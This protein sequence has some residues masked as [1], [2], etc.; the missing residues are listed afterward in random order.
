MQRMLIL[1]AALLGAGWEDVVLAQKA[2][3]EK[4]I[5]ESQPAIQDQIHRIYDVFRRAVRD[6]LK[7]NCEAFD[8]IQRLKNMTKDKGE[9]VKQLAIFT[10]TTES[11]EDTHVMLAGSILE[12]LNLPP[13][14]PIRVLAP[15]LDADNRP[16]RDFARI[17][18]HYHDSNT[19]IH[20]Q[21]PLGSVNYY[22]YM[23][24]VRS[25]MSTNVEDIPTA[26][27]EYMYEQQPDRALLVFCYA[28][29]Q[30]R[31]PSDILWGEHV[32]SNALWLKANGFEERYQKA[33]PEAAQELSKLSRYDE[34][35]ARRYV[36][37]MMRR[38]P[39]LR[40]P[41]VMEQFRKDS[42]ALV[43]KAAKSVKE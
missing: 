20:G 2:D 15:Y 1:V 39:E 24:Y 11:E 9:I 25:K 18:F 19:H 21:P 14:I 28:R 41:A 13:S 40:Q 6:D 31:V 37:E 27:V 34:W 26:L 10:A 7:T 33:L 42:N 23:V 22:D 30:R 32:V 43:S 4:L 36:V 5:A 3:V 29:R 8:E 17:W 35:W 16:L 38:Y 12:F